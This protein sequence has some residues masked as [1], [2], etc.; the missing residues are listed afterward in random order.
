MQKKQKKYTHLHM[1]YFFFI[2]FHLLEASQ[3]HMLIVIF[4]SLVPPWKK[5]EGHRKEQM[6]EGKRET[7]MVMF[8]NWVDLWLAVAIISP[9]T[10][11][12]WRNQAGQLQPEGG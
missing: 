1:L 9:F 4:P 6:R 8:F 3:Q 10:P 11:A 2:I 5:G 12:G 7:L